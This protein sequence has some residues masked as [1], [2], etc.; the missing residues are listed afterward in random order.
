[1][2]GRDRA[3]PVVL[4]WAVL[5]S[6]WALTSTVSARA[7]AEVLLLRARDGGAVR[8]GPRVAAGTGVSVATP[9]ELPIEG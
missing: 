3:R 8:L 5:S 4:L 7:G 6:A 9:V 2:A 1:M